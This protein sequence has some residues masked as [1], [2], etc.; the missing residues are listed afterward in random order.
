MYPDRMTP[1]PL[2]TFDGQATLLAE[3]GLTLD[4]SS[5]S[6]FLTHSNYYR[7][8]GYARYFQVAP[9]R[10]ND[11]FKPGATF[12]AVHRLHELDSELRAICFMGLGKAEASLRTQFAYHFAEKIGVYGQVDKTSSYISGSR[13]ENVADAVLRDLGRSKDAFIEHYRQDHDDY[14]VLPV[15]AAVEA[16]S[17]GTLSKGIAQ[18]S[19]Q[20]VSKSVASS[21]NIAWGGFVSQVRSLVYLRNKC[22]HHSRLW[23]HSVIDS[24]ATQNNIRNRAKK[25]HGNFEPRSVF[26]VLVA[27]DTYLKNTKLDEGFMD[28]VVTLLD[29]DAEFKRGLMDPKYPDGRSMSR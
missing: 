10:G 4:E 14:S 11:T 21:A 19:N 5:C 15:W 29:R 26:A 24:P 17:F 3:R 22:A 6:T 16:L 7:F 18:C 1:K 13:D 23:N 12:D 2:L 25:A 20:E 27:L 8:S 9:G 28:R